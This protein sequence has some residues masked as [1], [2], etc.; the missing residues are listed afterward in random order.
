M[1]AETL[2]RI[3]P[4]FAVHGTI[5][6]DY[7]GFVDLHLHPDGDTSDPAE[8]IIKA[9]ANSGLTGFA[10]TN[11]DSTR[12]LVRYQDVISGLGLDLEL[13]PGV[14]STTLMP[15]NKGRYNRGHP[16]H[17]LAFFEPSLLEQ[18]NVPDVPCYMP[19][20]EFNIFVHEHGGRTSVAHPAMGGFSFN[21]R[22]ILEVQADSDPNAHFD[23]AEGH[24]GGVVNLHRFRKQNPLL[25]ES[26]HAIGLLPHVLDTNGI[27][28]TFVEHKNRSLDLKGMTAGSDAHDNVHPGIS[29]VRY[30]RSNGLFFSIDNGEYALVQS[31]HMAPPWNIRGVY[32]G[33]IGGWKMEIDRRRGGRNGFVIYNGDTS[34]N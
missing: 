7:D 16:R 4:Q 6:H 32:K 5:K 19:A 15:D 25:A 9:A 18:G 31:S 29:G 34:K 22:Q 8:E 1:A 11:H 30:K 10:A 17:A 2:G 26:L 27:T 21:L 20:K 14:E 3:P 28:R 12:E 24:H 33:T 23:Y 13:I